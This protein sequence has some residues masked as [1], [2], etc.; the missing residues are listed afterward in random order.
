MWTKYTTRLC[1]KTPT[2]FIKKTMCKD[3]LL[4]CQESLGNH[5]GE[6]KIKPRE[7]LMAEESNC[8]WFCQLPKKFRMDKKTYGMKQS[9][10]E[11]AV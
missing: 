9:R 6:Y 11:F 10:S 2:F 1:L 3:K 7:K 5:Q 4:T 8:Q